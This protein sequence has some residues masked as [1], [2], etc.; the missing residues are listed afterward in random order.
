[1]MSEATLDTHLLVPQL[2]QPVLGGDE[3]FP[4]IET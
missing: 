1:M 4:L 2:G 3:Q